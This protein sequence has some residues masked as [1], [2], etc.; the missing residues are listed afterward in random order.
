[1]KIDGK[2]LDEMPYAWHD[3]VTHGNAHI[4]LTP[5]KL[6]ARPESMAKL[7]Q[8]KECSGKAV[9]TTSVQNTGMRWMPFER[10]YNPQTDFPNNSGRVETLR[11]QGTLLEETRNIHA[12]DERPGDERIVDQRKINVARHFTNTWPSRLPSHQ[13]RQLEHGSYYLIT[14]DG[15]SRQCRDYPDFAKFVDAVQTGDLPERILHVAGPQLHNFLCQT[16]LY[17]PALSLFGHVG[18]RRVEPMPNL[19]TVYDIARNQ[20]GQVQV[21]Y[22]ARD[23]GL[24]RAM[25]VGIEDYDEHEASALMPASIRFSG[26]LLF[27]PDGAC[28]IGPVRMHATAMQF[29][30]PTALA[31]TD[32]FA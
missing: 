2:K 19:R 22:T 7:M 20:Q 6:Q 18:Q 17:N 24:D 12:F 25:L 29:S 15:Q 1:M 14:P 9:S 16:Y 8:A 27:S 11:P 28:A 23:D 13:Q 32:S 26:S 4:Q 31:V 30:E 3:V 5:P 10:M 21:R